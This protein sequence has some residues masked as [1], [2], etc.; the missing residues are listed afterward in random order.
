MLFSSGF[1]FFIK[2][3]WDDEVL[4]G[5]VGGHNNVICVR[6]WVWVLP[7]KLVCSAVGFCVWRW[8][9]VAI[10]K[11]TQRTYVD[12]SDRWINIPY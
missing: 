2:I 7:R 10:V 11:L 5:G 4:A 12:S 1:I 9:D 8:V 3:F 6:K